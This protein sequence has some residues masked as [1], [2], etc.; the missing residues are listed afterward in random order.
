MTQ[1]VELHEITRFKEHGQDD[2]DEDEL[3]WAAVERVQKETQYRRTLDLAHDRTENSVDRSKDSAHGK[4][5]KIQHPATLKSAQERHAF[6]DKLL[7]KI[8]EDNRKLLL[9]QRERIDRYIN[10]VRSRLLK[11][12]DHSIYIIFGN[13]SIYNYAILT[14]FMIVFSVEWV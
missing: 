7:K 9:K 13:I 4:Q 2:D 10:A 14:D 1:V 6:I 11:R 3:Q 12:K 8:E 5:V